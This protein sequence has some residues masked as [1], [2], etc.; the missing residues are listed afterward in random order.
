MTS[1]ADA[2]PASVIII[3]VHHNDV[4]V[5]MIMAIGA[6]DLGATNAGLLAV[7][8]KTTEY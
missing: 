8:N 7:D 3:L 5:T 4:T 2:I 1:A 6:I